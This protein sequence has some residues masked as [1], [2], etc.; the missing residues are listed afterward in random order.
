V[1]ASDEHEARLRT[2]IA[3]GARL[4]ETQPVFKLDAFARWLRHLR[5]AG[6]DVPVLWT[7]R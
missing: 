2:K 1:D 3:A 4:L 7:S 5:E 6:I